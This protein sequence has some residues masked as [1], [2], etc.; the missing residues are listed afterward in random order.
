VLLALLAVPV[1]A[2]AQDDPFGDSEFTSPKFGTVIEWSD[3]WRLD[4]D[5]SGV[6][7]RRDVIGLNSRVNEAGVLIELQSQRSFRTAESFINAAMERY[8][9][10]VGFEQTA[11][12]LS[13]YPPSLT[14]EFGEEDDRI[15]GHIQAQAIEGA[16]MAVL[17]LGRP[18]DVEQWMENA[19]DQ[20]E[21]NGVPLLE[22]LPICGEA[23]GDSDTATPAASSS[24]GDSKTGG[25]GDASDDTNGTCV[26][27]A[28]PAPT[29]GNA[30]ETPE[31][32]PTTSSGR[33]G[34][35][36]NTTYT[37]PTY[38]SVSLKYNRNN[39]EIAEEA[40]AD[41]NNGR[42]LLRLTHTDLP[43]VL[44]IETYAG[45]NGRAAACIDVA[46]G[47]VGIFPGVD[48]PLQDE[49]GEL[50]QGTERGRVW[51]AYAFEIETEDGPLDAGG[52]VECRSLPGAAGV[53]VITLVV[54]IES[55]DDA[56]QE[57]QPILR[58]IVLG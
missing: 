43:A 35:L 14:F 30:E 9:S 39:W 51:G 10:L 41:E 47:E 2:F 18:G 1:M 4:R 25:F 7:Q 22:A 5:Q 29:S 17:V 26:E 19:N 48:E 50:I 8:T 55:F 27:V 15:A 23:T 58:S 45:H 57:L 3:D 20:I 11:E 46:L 37:S 36:N 34:G 56:Y 49:N 38:P 33:G 24:S 40:S 42:D 16:M 13:A 28:T 12:D 53:L 6:Q 52:Y 21:V 31:P 44:Y 54:R 32:T